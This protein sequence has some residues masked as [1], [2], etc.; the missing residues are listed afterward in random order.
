MTRQMFQILLQLAT[1]LFCVITT[2]NACRA[3]MHAEAVIETLDK[4]HTSAKSFK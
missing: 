3:H 1:L 4:V 2:A